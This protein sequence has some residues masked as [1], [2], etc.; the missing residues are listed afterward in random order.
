MRMIHN[1]SECRM[2]Q[3][4][5]M[6]LIEPLPSILR[7]TPFTSLIPFGHNFVRLIFNFIRNSFQ[8]ASS[9][10]DFIQPPDSLLLPK[11][12]FSYIMLLIFHK[13]IE[14]LSEHQ[15]STR[16]FMNRDCGG[17]PSNDFEYYR[18]LDAGPR[19]IRAQISM[20]F[21]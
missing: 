7:N 15:F 12:S 4:I 8:C 6:N 5:I 20:S 1:V 18:K 21:G 2:P 13:T 9:T 16:P 3:D 11:H 17:L 10:V 14:T 19:L